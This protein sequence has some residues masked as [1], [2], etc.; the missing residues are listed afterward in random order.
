MLKIFQSI[1]CRLIQRIK[2]HSKKSLSSY[3]IDASI[4][5]GNKTEW[6]PIRSVI[7]PVITNLLI[8]SIITDLIGRH[9]VLLPIDD[10]NYNFREKKNGQV[11]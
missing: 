3:F 7:I 1:M 11:M 2:D 9:E 10:K 6:S 8:T 5:N 4:G